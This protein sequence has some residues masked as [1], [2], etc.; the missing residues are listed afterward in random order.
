M[1]PEPVTFIMQA[2]P[3]V[4]NPAA[5]DTMGCATSRTGIM[6]FRPASGSVTGVT[7]E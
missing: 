4:V 6:A 2:P 7:V 1:P 5:W 3:V